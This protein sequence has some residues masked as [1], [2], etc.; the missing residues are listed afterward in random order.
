M[1]KVQ[2]SAISLGLFS[3]IQSPVLWSEKP[4]R[5]QP[6]SLMGACFQANEHHWEPDGGVGRGLKC[7]GHRG[8]RW[9]P[10]IL[11][12]LNPAGNGG[13]GGEWERWAVLTAHPARGP[14]V[15]SQAASL[16]RLELYDALGVSVPR[17]VEART[18]GQQWRRRGLEDSNI[19]S[20]VKSWS[21]AHQSY[22][23]KKGS[24]GEHEVCLAGTE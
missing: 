8:G 19:L 13:E 4:C 1:F 10:W 23:F 12:F 20:R 18:I 6:P 11:P 16:Q 17:W 24:A 5:G 15:P 22:R 2:I 9:S 3:L 21:R 7:W 14:K